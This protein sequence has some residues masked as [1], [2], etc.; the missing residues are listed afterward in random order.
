M[1]SLVG[2]VKEQDRDL[3]RIA[4]LARH[5]RPKPLLPLMPQSNV[6]LFDRMD[7]G[8]ALPCAH[9]FF[10]GCAWNCW[11][12]PRVSYVDEV[13]NHLSKHERE[14]RECLGPEIPKSE[15]LDYYEEAAK[16]KERGEAESGSSATMPTVGLS[17]DRRVIAHVSE[18]YQEKKVMCL[19]CFVCAEKNLFYDGYDRH[20]QSTKL[21][22]DIAYRSVQCMVDALKKVPNDASFNH[23]LNFAV[24]RERYCSNRRT[25]AGSQAL[26]SEPDLQ[27]Y[28]WRRRWKRDG[29]VEDVLC[30]PEDVQTTHHCKHEACI[31]CR[32]CQVPVCM[33]CWHRLSHPTLFR[34]PQSLANDN[35]KGYAHEFIVRNQVRW[36]EAVTACPHFSVLMTYYI[37]GQ[38]GHIM[39]EKLGEQRRTYGSRGN[40]FSFALQWDDILQFMDART[41]DEQL[42]AWPHAPDV[43]SHWVRI[44]LK[45]AMWI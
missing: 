32:H 33:E 30:C 15:W 17:I 23:N 12:E 39:E 35:Y 9:C 14:I 37:E 31:L 22:G 43:V 26:A 2:L 5:F 20:G 8:I 13:L 4:A 3:Q 21:V 29:K 38:K 7:E 18:V 1:T 19:I 24:F 44:V 27:N 41:T 28:E 36:I 6:A 25:D 16:M 45:K 10:Q 11:Q 40:L 34:I 42:S